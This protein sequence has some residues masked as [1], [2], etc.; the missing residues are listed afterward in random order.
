MGTNDD[1][2]ACSLNLSARL[3]L[4]NTRTSLYCWPLYL[5]SYI[6][7]NFG[8]PLPD[9][10]KRRYPHF[11]RLAVDP[12][13]LATR[14]ATVEV[15]LPRQHLGPEVVAPTLSEQTRDPGATREA[16]PDA[17]LYLETLLAP[18]VLH[19]VDQ[20]SYQ[21]FVE[22]LRVQL[23][24]QRH[25]EAVLAHEGVTLPLFGLDEQLVGRERDLLS[26]HRHRDGLP[27]GG[28]RADLRRRL[29]QSIPDAGHEP[30][31]LG[32]DDPEVRFEIVGDNVLRLAE[33]ELLDV[34]LVQD[35]LLQGLH[36]VPELRVGRLARH[37]HDL[38]QGLAGLY[39]G[40]VAGRPTQGHDAP[41]GRH[42]LREVPVNE[43]L[44]DC[45]PVGEVYALGSFL[46]HV[47]D[48]VLV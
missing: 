27:V 44:F 5:G 33:G 40:G 24:A 22:E 28:S 31:V 18:E 36:S 9:L 6:I 17:L 11:E 13:A 7:P 14:G 1:S 42:A 30:A 38:P 43:R 19:L 25:G 3:F 4:P 20:L 23:G 12:H 2:S 47:H 41:R 29:R 35:D 39:G 46:V 15:E 16:H 8:G 34:Q 37:D 32:P 45:R 10:A 21:P 26:L 48:E